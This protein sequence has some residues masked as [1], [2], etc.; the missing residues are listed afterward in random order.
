MVGMT[1][2]GASSA[3]LED[4]LLEWSLLMPYNFCLRRSSLFWMS[5]FKDLEEEV[6]EDIMFNLPNYS[7]TF[8]IKL[9]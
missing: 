8:S 7:I 4:M 3:C 9:N 1:N 6:C 5:G 2:L